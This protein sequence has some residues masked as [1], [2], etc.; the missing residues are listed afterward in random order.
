MTQKIKISPSLLSADFGNLEKE[1]SEI[2]AAGADLI[3]IDVMDGHFVPNLTLGPA[4]V[5]SIRKHTT[6]PFDVHLMVTNPDKFIESFSEAGADALTIHVE[7][8]QVKSTLEDIKRR[9]KKAGL[10]LNPETPVTSLSP[11]LN[12]IDLV[13]IMT[14]QPGFG[15]Q[16]FMENQVEKVEWLHAQKKKN[17]LS[18]DIS[19]DGGVSE[20]NAPSLIQKGAT[21]L[22]AGTSVF[23]KGPCHYKDAIKNLRG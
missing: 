6:L 13:L 2:T 8:S 23:G 14:V 17:G 21:I 9:G 1:V 4:I 5:R 10:S 19:V 20:E 22:V 11:Y 3:H 12:D 7:T 16:K 18:F 15:G